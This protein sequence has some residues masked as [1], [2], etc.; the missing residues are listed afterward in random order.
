MT[1][2]EPATVELT[3]ATVDSIAAIQALY[4]EAG[5]TQTPAQV[6]RHA[7]ALL[8]MALV[9]KVAF[10]NDGDLSGLLAHLPAEGVA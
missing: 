7:T 10:V 1:D 5:V 9:G 8:M 6:V 3:P 2:T 4:E